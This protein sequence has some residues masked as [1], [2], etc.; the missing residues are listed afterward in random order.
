MK[1]KTDCTRRVGS[2]WGGSI[3][4]VSPPKNINQMNCTQGTGA[5]NFAGL[6]EFTCRYG[7]CPEASCVC[8]HWGD[9]EKEP[10]ETGVKGY[11]L[12][13]TSPAYVGLCSWACNHGYCPSSACGTVDGGTANPNTSPFLPPACTKGTGSGPFTG[14]CDYACN[15]G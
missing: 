9:L 3:S 4:A 8:T 13:G 10:K 15:F 7:Y 2:S 1:A 11:P 14:L 12:P 5:N 6:C